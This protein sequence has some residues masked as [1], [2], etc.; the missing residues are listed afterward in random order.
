MSAAQLQATPVPAPTP[1]SALSFL[2]SGDPLAQIVV[3]I[4]EALFILLVALVLARFIK[5][6]IVRIFTRGRV[7]VNVA[8]LVGNL[9]Q[10]GMVLIGAITALTV[11][12]VPWASL[13][14]V[15]GVAGLAISLSL[16]DLLKNVVAGVYILMEQPFR[17]GDRISVKD[18]TGIVQAIELRT[19]I[20]RTDELLQVVVPNNVVLNEIVTNRSASSVIRVTV[21]ML[22]RGTASADVVD[23]VKEA[24]SGVPD[25]APTPAPIIDLEGISD[26]MSQMRIDFWV[27]AG[28][29]VAVTAAVI[30]TLEA[31]FQQADLKVAV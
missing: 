22:L 3:N 1:G 31:R 15:L 29:K 2:T 23:Q 7:N 16:Q 14:A 4:L 6:W 26:G 30:E 27:P 19:T 25:V 11:I 28:K 10:V 20:L 24:L 18:V 9:A 12:G 5:A 8:Q 21:R 17:I 13:V